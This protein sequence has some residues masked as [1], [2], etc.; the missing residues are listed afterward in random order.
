MSVKPDIN[1]AK[2]IGNYKLGFSLRRTNDLFVHMPFTAA[3]ILVYVAVSELESHDRN[4]VIGLLNVC[5]QALTKIGHVE[6]ALM[7]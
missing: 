4:Q 6:S 7:T 1:I 3:L 5:C 2:H